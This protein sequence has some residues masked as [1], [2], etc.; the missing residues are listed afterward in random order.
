MWESSRMLPVVIFLAI[1]IFCLGAA[2]R[3]P[4]GYIACACAF[5]ALVL[6]LI[7]P[8]GVR[9]DNPTPRPETAYA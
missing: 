6:M 2:V 5:I 4:L 1:A 7:W 3:Q 8:H 9:A